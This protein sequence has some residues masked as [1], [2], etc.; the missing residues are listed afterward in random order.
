MI[1]ELGNYYNYPTYTTLEV[2]R[3]S[4]IEFPAVTICNLNSLSKSLVL[5]D[6]RVDNYYLSIGPRE[7]F[8]LH[9]RFNWSD[10]FYEQNGF[11]RNRTVKEILSKHKRLHYGLCNSFMFDQTLYWD[12]EEY[13]SVKL[14]PNGPCLTSNKT[15]IFKTSYTG[16]AYNFVMWL[17]VDHE[18]SYFGQWLGEGVQFTVHDKD[19]DPH[20]Q[21]SSGYFIEPGHEYYGA[22]RKYTHEYLSEPFKATPTE[23][24]RESFEDGKKYLSTKCWKECYVSYIYEACKCIDFDYK[25]YPICSKYEY[26]KCARLAK[27]E[28]YGNSKMKTGCH[29]PP[30]CSSTR[31]EVTLSSSIFPSD[32]YNDLLLKAVY[33]NDQDYYRKNFIVIH[34]YFDELKTTIVKQ[35][36]VYGSSVEI[37]GNLGGQMGLFIGA[38]ILT[39]TELGEFLGFVLWFI[40][41]KCKNRNRPNFSKE[42]NDIATLQEM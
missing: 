26:F 28:F 13:F 21:G 7:I 39:I 11:F 22:L 10:P 29:C 4:E 5:N 40:L 27:G 18:N 6:S 32:F 15:K 42:K 37:F 1:Q 30:A 38:S 12:L 2:E 34:I 8:D 19:E 35:S 14:T 17:N 20:F 31:Y 33:K 3:H 16:S 23:F 25:D 41:K 24:C 9:K 36:A